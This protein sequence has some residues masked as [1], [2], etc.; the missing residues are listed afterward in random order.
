MLTVETAFATAYAN[1]KK[2]AAAAKTKSTPK[3]TPKATAKTK[4]TSKAEIGTAD[5]VPVVL[6]SGGEGS[7]WVQH[8]LAMLATVAAEIAEVAE[9]IAEMRELHIVMYSDEIT[10]GQQIKRNDRKCQ[11]VYWSLVNFGP[12]LLCFESMWFTAAALR[13]SEC[14]KIQGGMSQVY[15]RTLRLFFGG[16]G[17]HDL[18][19]GILLRLQ[20]SDA[21]KLV[22]GKLVAFLQGVRPLQGRFGRKTGY[23]T[24]RGHRFRTIDGK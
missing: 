20:G 11:T 18:R 19:H 6:A 12:E 8:P 16:R 14:K 23:T 21:P 1:A 4:V 13:V 15:K 5:V 17:R 10:P 2:T 7:T 22:V 3:A 24:P 9:L